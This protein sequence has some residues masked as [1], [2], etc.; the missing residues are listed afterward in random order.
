MPFSA[1]AVAVVAGLI[2]FAA[3]HGAVSA[4]AS[5]ADDAARYL[6]GMQPSA[7]S[8]LMK[9]TRDPGWQ[10]HARSFDAAWKKL[11]REQIS[12]IRAWSAENLKEQRETLF[13]TFSGPD[14]LYANAF[15]P[16]ASTYVLAGLEPVGRIPEITGRTAYSLPSLR[17]SLNTALNLSFFITAHMRQQLQQGELSGTLPILYV[18]IARSGNTI[19]DVTL[20][21]LDK[22]GI[23]TPVDQ[24]RPRQAVDGVKIVF[25]RGDDAPQTLYYFRTDLSDSGVKNSGFLKFCEKLG[26]GDSLLKSASYLLHRQSFSRTRQFLIE[27][28]R[29]IVQDDSGIPMSAFKPDEWQLNLFGKYLGPI[30]TFPEHNQPKLRQLYQQSKPGKLDFGIGYRWRPNESNLLVAVKKPAKAASQ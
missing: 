24:V 3:S 27:H 18:F 22:D 16:K 12:R 8:P 25:A 7:E 29:S 21:N 30:G 13:Y 19:K 5:R 17:A 15:F 14:F 9:F 26:T 2:L 28:S 1:K 20:V 11:D 10:Q 6:A 23:V 4:E